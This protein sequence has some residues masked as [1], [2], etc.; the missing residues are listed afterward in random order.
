MNSYGIRKRIDQLGRITIPKSFRAVVGMDIGDEV[1]ICQTD[2]GILI[3]PIVKE[4]EKD[5]NE[6]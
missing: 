3:K 2:A 4:E 1:E 5:R 6:N